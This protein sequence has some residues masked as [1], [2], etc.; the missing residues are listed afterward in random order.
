VLAFAEYVHTLVLDLCERYED[1][2]QGHDHRRELLDEQKWRAIRHGRETAFLDQEMRGTITLTEFLE[3][4]SD[5]LDTN[6]LW[7]VY[8][9]ESGAEKQRRIRDSAGVDALCD[10]LI[11]RRA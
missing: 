5:R 4:E 8:E 1:G 2:E 3:R 7:S 6:A 9:A 11:L 10:A